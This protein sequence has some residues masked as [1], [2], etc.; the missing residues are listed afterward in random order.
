MPFTSSASTNADPSGTS[1]CSRVR[2][3]R[4]LSATMQQ[5]RKASETHCNWE[6]VNGDK[7]KS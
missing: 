4:L 2:E 1:P 7:K 3:L 5:P 6:A